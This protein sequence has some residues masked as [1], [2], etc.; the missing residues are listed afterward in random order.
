MHRLAL[1]IDPVAYIRNVLG[2]KSPDPI[3]ILVLAELGGA[4]SIV[5]YYRDDLK[6]VSER[7]INLFKEIVKTYLNIRSN[8]TEKN[9][10]N[11]LTIKPDMV[12]FV[13]PGEV[14][15]VEPS[16]LDLETYS[17]QLQSYIAELRSNNILSSILIDPDIQQIKLAGKLEF[18]YVELNAA[19]L[20]SATDMDSELAILDEISSF[21]LAANKIG[22]G[23]NIS[24]NI[25]Y[26]NIRELAKID[27]LE[28]IIVGKPILNKAL[29]I[30]FEQAVRDF[31]T[32]L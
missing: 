9:I 10:R 14:T 13:A 26:D 22:M 27:Y 15:T 28:D 32:L 25:D 2:E 21:S 18:D 4:E 11:L 20:S 12:T 23:I 7:D 6:T 3:H 17:S 8:L 19:H 30:G 16:P 5:C 1:D 24:G 31:I 29:S